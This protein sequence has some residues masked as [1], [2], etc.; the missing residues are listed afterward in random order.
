[1]ESRRSTEIGDEERRADAFTD[2]GDPVKHVP[3]PEGV[4]V[5]SRV[6]A[7]ERTVSV[8]ARVRARNVVAVRGVRRHVRC[9]E[10]FAWTIRAGSWT[11]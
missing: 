9:T 4:G 7:R 8:T 6:P 3:E 10:P 2:R 5:A 11:S 1:M